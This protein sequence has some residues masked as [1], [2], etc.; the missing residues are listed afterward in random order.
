MPESVPACITFLGTLCKRGESSDAKDADHGGKLMRVPSERKVN[1]VAKGRLQP[2]AMQRI[3][4]GP[5]K[6][7]DGMPLGPRLGKADGLLC[8]GYFNGIVEQ[9]FY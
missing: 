7:L 4:D 8:Q 3:D 9:F 6:I 2:K 5:V 1:I